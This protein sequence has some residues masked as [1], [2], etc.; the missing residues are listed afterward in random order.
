MALAIN[1]HG[2]CSGPSGTGTGFLRVLPFPLPIIPLTAPHSATSGAG[3]VGQTVAEVPSRPN[4]TPPK[5]T[6]KGS[7][8]ICLENLDLC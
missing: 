1:R 5:E 8:I 2:I 6:R 4:L 3:A 7:I